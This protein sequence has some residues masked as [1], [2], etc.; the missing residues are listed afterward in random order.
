M[1]T[2]L[3]SYEGM[4]TA[5]VL[6]CGAPL[7]S[8]KLIDGLWDFPGSFPWTMTFVL[9]NADIA[10]CRRLSKQKRFIS[11]VYAPGTDRVEARAKHDHLFKVFNVQVCTPILVPN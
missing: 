9:R 11:I 5:A 7:T 4:G 3:Q 6:V 10:R 1:V 8:A 2:Y